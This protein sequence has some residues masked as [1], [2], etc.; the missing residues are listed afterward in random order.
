MDPK[1]K[2]LRQNSF[3]AEIPKKAAYFSSASSFRASA[4]KSD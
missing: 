3:L 2:E 4:A 1:C